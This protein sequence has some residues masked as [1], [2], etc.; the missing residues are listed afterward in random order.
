MTHK[1][2][3]VS[4]RDVHV[5]KSKNY[6]KVKYHEY[7]KALAERS[8][9]NYEEFI[10]RSKKVQQNKPTATWEGINALIE[11]IKRNGFDPDKSS[12]RLE[13]REYNG[14][15]IWVV[16]HGRH[17]TC[18]LRYLYGRRLKFVIDDKGKILELV[19]I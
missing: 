1:S 17:R 6:V 16:C 18:I 7:F 19:G 10:S 15:K 14:K 2:Q 5:H 13:K 8:R 9:R 11:K 3:I 12:F 4:I